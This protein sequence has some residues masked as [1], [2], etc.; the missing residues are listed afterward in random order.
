[1]KPPQG[2]FDVLSKREVLAHFVIEKKIGQ[3]AMGEVYLAQDVQLHRKVAIKVLPPE[4]GGN[5]ERLGRFKRE[6]RAASA[7]S[8]ANIAH[9]Y[10]IGE[11]N[12]VHFIAMEYVDGE[13]LG[14]RILAGTLSITDAIDIGI[15]LADALD[16]AHTAKVVHR[17]IKPANILLT[18]NNRIKILDFGIARMDPDASPLGEVEGKTTLDAMTSPG[19]IVG[20]VPYMSPEQAL[21]RPVGPRSDIFSTGSVLYELFA[22]Q[23]AFTG[24]PGMETLNKVIN[25]AP[26]PPSR[27]NPK[28]PAELEQIIFHCLEKDP[29]LRYQN[30]RDLRNDL[31]NLL[32]DLTLAIPSRDRPPTALIR[33]KMG[34]PKPKPTLGRFGWWIGSAAALLVVLA[35][36][37]AWNHRQSGPPTVAVMPFTVTK[38]PPQLEYLGSGLTDGLIRDLSRI[39]GVRVTSG[40]VAA[41]AYQAHKDPISA[42]RELGA[43]LVL[44]GSIAQVESGL[45]FNVTLENPR[46]AEVMWAQTYHKKLDDLKDVQEMIRQSITDRLRIKLEGDVESRLKQQYAIG[47]EANRLYM[48]GRFHL[49]KR[50]LEDI[51][52]AIGLF[53]QV[54]DRHPEYGPTYAGLADAYSLVALFNYESPKGPLSQAR[55]AAERAVENDDSLSEA[56][57]SHGL[58]MSILDYNW[59]GAERDFQRAIALNPDYVTAHTWYAIWVLSPMGRHTEAISRMNQALTLDKNGMVTRLCQAQIYYHARRFDDAISVA[60]S[61]LVEHPDFAPGKVL[62]S[63]SYLAKGQMEEAVKLFPDA[64]NTEWALLRVY[65]LARGNRLE[66][67]KKELAEIEAREG[68]TFLPNGQRAACYVALGDFE[69]ALHYLDIAYENREPMVVTAKVEPMFDPIRKNP[70]FIGLVDKIKLN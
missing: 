15:Q 55:K 58:V 28:M 26:P 4:L 36:G 66:Q 63:L 2:E 17:D 62:L 21:G 31:Q 6:A 39:R 29:D 22:G 45:D 9:I 38:L 12:G 44:Y 47:S 25:E 3:G 49:E 67:A 5:E 40:M 43:D 34:A 48:E 10:E 50:R 60:Q 33:S 20:T 8:H 1:V 57:V 52:K 30:I 64:S 11:A 16:A 42:A 59:T 14:N 70:R 69:K 56:H 37:F 46:R 19:I 27:F 41:Q 18:A 54:A 7:V 32:R 51:N 23:R 35:L 53:Q 61:T 13:T 24:A 68:T 65:V